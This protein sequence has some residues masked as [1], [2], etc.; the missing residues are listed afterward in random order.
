MDWLLRA[1]R[2]T[3]S[4]RAPIVCYLRENGPIAYALTL[5]DPD[6]RAR[7]DAMLDSGLAWYWR[8]AAQ[9]DRSG[10]QEW[11]Q[12]TRWAMAALLADLAA[13][14]E[15]RVLSPESDV[16]DRESEIDVTIVGIDG[17]DA[18]TELSDRRVAPWVRDFASDIA[19]PLHIVV[20]RPPDLVFVAQQ[21]PAAVRDLLYAWGVDRAQTERRAYAKLETRSLEHWLKS[22]RGAMRGRGGS[23]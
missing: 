18:P 11:T 3:G 12:L 17:A 13:T 1:F 15:S 9:E 21:P 6:P 5:F 7:V 10:A 4:A 14:S 8:K 22:L 16:R 23:V 20:R 2:R 19:S